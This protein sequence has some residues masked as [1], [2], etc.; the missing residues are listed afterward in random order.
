MLQQDGLYSFC[1]WLNFRKLNPESE[2]R[3]SANRRLRDFSGLAGFG[4]S[5]LPFTEP[6]RCYLT[7]L[8]LSRDREELMAFYDF[9]AKH[10]HPYHQSD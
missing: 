10:W 4:R 9:P 8:E 3:K 1:R 2:F 5:N 7:P 6:D